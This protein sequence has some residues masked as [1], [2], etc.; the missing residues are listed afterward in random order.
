MKTKYVFLNINHSITLGDMK[1]MLEK[2][3]MDAL[4]H[5]DCADFSKFLELSEMA[6][7]SLENSRKTL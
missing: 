1:H 2:K 3:W 6:Y 7:L 5:L 4:D